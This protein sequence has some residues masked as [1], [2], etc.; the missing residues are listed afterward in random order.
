ME[1][2]GE[3]FNRLIQWATPKGLMKQEEF[4]VA[5]YLS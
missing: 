4:K 3:V 2:I 1:E 5:Y